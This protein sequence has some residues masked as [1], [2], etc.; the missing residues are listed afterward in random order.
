MSW[1]VHESRPENTRP[2][3]VTAAA[4]WWQPLLPLV[5][6]LHVLKKCKIIELWVIQWELWANGV[7][8]NKLTRVCCL[9]S[10][11]DEFTS[12]VHIKFTQIDGQME[13]GV[14]ATPSRWIQ[15]IRE[16]EIDIDIKWQKAQNKVSCKLRG[17]QETILI[18]LIKERC[19]GNV[20]WVELQP[21][22]SLGV[23]VV[24]PTSS[25]HDS[26]ITVKLKASTFIQSL[27][28]SSLHSPGQL[29]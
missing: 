13:S 16:N 12:R 8:H 21:R 23:D 25:S 7:I 22:R 18:P 5:M 29:I 24:S 3:G 28:H 1:D 10:S 9:Q 14:E 26:L 6:I 15:S 27:D 19:E 17:A 11:L 2:A 4:C 20:K